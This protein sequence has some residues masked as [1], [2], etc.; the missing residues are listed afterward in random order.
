M[1]LRIHANDFTE[2]MPIFFHLV[3]SP[4]SHHEIVCNSPFLHIL[5][6]NLFLIFSYATYSIY[7]YACFYKRP[8][9]ITTHLTECAISEQLRRLSGI[10]LH[11]QIFNT[12]LTYDDA[13]RR[14][15]ENIYSSYR[16]VAKQAQIAL[17]Y[18]S[19]NLANRPAVDC[20]RR[21]Q[22]FNKC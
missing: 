12:P 9:I 14:E 5:V 15:L 13:G 16:K 20:T 22:T 2:A 1:L 7:V 19:T 18:W 3:P 17:F 6:E 4:S 10:E 11:S 21:G 8:R